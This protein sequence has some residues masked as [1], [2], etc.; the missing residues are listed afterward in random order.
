[1]SMT[2][3]GGGTPIISIS[4]APMYH[5]DVMQAYH[6]DVAAQAHELQQACSM[7]PLTVWIVSG[8]RR[9]SCLCTLHCQGGAYR[10]QGPSP[11]SC[12]V[13]HRRMVYLY[14]GVVWKFGIEASIRFWWSL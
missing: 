6:T 13:S 8:A 1:M 10:L 7:T 5:T 4:N 11:F 9:C 2:Q 14:N 12:Q 3:G